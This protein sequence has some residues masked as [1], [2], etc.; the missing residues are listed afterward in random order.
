MKL[1]SM[2]ADA[3]QSFAP[4]DE[5][6]DAIVQGARTTFLSLGYDG[7]SMDQIAL[8]AGVSKRTV[9]NRFRSKEE[10]FGAAIEETC[11]NLLPVNV[12]EIEA[13]L[14]PEEFILQ[15]S[16]QFVE[17]ILQPEALALRRIASFEAGRTPEIGRCYL[18]HGPEWMVEQCAPI[19]ERLSA[20]GA[21]K[22]DDPRAALWRLGALITE[23]LHTQLLLGASS[24]DLKKAIDDQVKNGV[25][26][27]FTLHAP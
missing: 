25:A 5:K 17:G 3:T 26:A 6:T 24:P 13:S 22:A 8:T 27:F 20:R 15:L 2:M 19:I 21:L 7:A 9:Y 14:P 18:K 23:P 1:N 16:R 4:I 10:L 12:E 11:R